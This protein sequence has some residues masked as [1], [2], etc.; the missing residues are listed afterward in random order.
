MKIYIKFITFAMG[1]N[2]AW[3]PYVEE[4]R[5]KHNAEIMCR[6]Y[7][8]SLFEKKYPNI[9]FIEENG[10][11]FAEKWA[12]KSFRIGYYLELERFKWHGLKDPRDCN[13]QEIA[14]EM[15]DLEYKP[16]KPLIDVKNKR[17]ITPNKYVCIASHA[18]A[19]AKYWNYPNGWEKVCE[20]LKSKNYEIFSID[21]QTSWGTL[22]HSNSVPKN[23]INLTGLSPDDTANVIYNCDFFIGLSS[24]LSWL[25]WA[26][27]KRVILISGFSDP[28]TEFY[29][30]YRLINRNVCNSCWNS[31]EAAFDF[32]DFLWCPKHRN[33]QK[34]F[35]CSKSITPEQVTNCID[36]II[37][38]DAKNQTYTYPTETQMNEYLNAR[39]TCQ[40][41]LIAGVMDGR[42]SGD[43]LFEKFLIHHKKSKIIFVEPVDSFLIKLKENVNS[44]AELKES[45]I[46]YENSCLGEFNKDV[47]IG[48]L[49]E[50]Y[51]N[52]YHLYT[53]GFS[54]VIKNG[55]FSN[56]S[57]GLYN[58]PLDHIDLIKKPMINLS[59][60]MKKYGFKNHIDYIELDISGYEEYLLEDLSRISFNILTFKYFQIDPDILQNFID[61]MKV[62]NYFYHKYN[63]TILFYKKTN[64]LT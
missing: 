58:V 50:K 60:L 38:E 64:L 35:E 21:K 22:V 39:R 32:N 47:Y 43:L 56:Q 15:L 55:K 16:I 49:K 3:M 25:A 14:A 9:K 61:K 36:Q 48:T 28:K 24:G 19:Q 11:S 4:Y 37:K 20:Y 29:T 10:E 5:K 54:C 53:N 26:L 6:T 1:D 2:I 42:S 45:E 57:I 12:D 52:S 63:D 8:N 40:S 46:F 33:T 17:R 30:P 7:F 62:K 34:M 18:S 51:L 31:K 41:F 13:L 59:E 44:L 27:N 23:S